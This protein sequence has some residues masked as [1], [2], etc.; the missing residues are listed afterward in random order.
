MRPLLKIA[1]TAVFGISII[2]A[3]RLYIVKTRRRG[4]NQIKKKKPAKPLKRITPNNSD[5]KL[6]KMKSPPKKPLQA[7]DSDI[8]QP[9]PSNNAMTVPESKES[10]NRSPQSSKINLN[11]TDL[12]DCSEARAIPKCDKLT[13]FQTSTNSEQSPA[14]AIS[15]VAP[16]KLTG[17]QSQSERQEIEKMPNSFRELQDSKF[18]PAEAPIPKP[19]EERKGSTEQST[20]E[21]T[22]LAGSQS[23]S[24]RQEIQQ[25][26][27]S[28][29]ELQDSK[30]KPAPSPKSEKGPAEQSL[31]EPSPVP[32]NNRRN[33]E[34]SQVDTIS[35]VPTKLVGT[36]SPSERQEIEQMPNSF[37]EL[38]DSKFKPAQAPNPKPERVERGSA[39]QSMS[40]PLSISRVAFGSPIA[41]KPRPSPLQAPLLETLATPPTIDAPT[42]AIETAIE[43][44]A[45]FSSSHSMDP[46][47]SLFKVCRC[48]KKDRGGLLIDSDAAVYD[49]SIKANIPATKVL[50]VNFNKY[51]PPNLLDPVTGGS[52]EILELPETFFTPLENSP[53]T[54]LTGMNPMLGAMNAAHQHACLINHLVENYEFFE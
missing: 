20:T 33:S 12:K 40:E 19:E 42:A 27:N 43:R 25:M 47:N 14:D 16:T 35:P 18:K 54:Y 34:T 44:S 13:D 5:E 48:R 52:Y 2:V 15:A 41:P 3:Y 7:T 6:K 24:E 1:L 46:S 26:P 4:G 29:R 17:S 11:T 45:E 10:A 9:L 38:Q 36:Q 22:K 37:R 8:L 28:F 32:G 49:P 39:E 51:N 21:P 50:P 31:S 23:P 30:F 53:D